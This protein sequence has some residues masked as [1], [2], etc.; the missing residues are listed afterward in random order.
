MIT[1]EW[2]D[3]EL[4]GYCDLH[5]RTDRALFHRDHVRRMF[6]LAG[7]PVPEIPEWVSVPAWD[8]EPLVKAARA[9]CSKRVMKIDIN[10]RTH[11]VDKDVLT[12]ADVVKLVYADEPKRAAWYLETPGAVLTIVYDTKRDSE[13]RHRDGCLSIGE[14]VRIEE[15][16]RFS[17]A[18]TGNA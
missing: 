6:E 18:N 2:T 8:M 7:E 4:I 13:G 5:S 16:M 1:P 10:G 17:A 15:G 12:Y 9:R 14:T 11:E 3:E